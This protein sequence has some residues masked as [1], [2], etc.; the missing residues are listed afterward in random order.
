MNCYKV[1]VQSHIPFYWLILL[2]LQIIVYILDEIFY[3]NIKSNNNP[4]GDMITDEKLQ[5]IINK[6]AAKTSALLAG[7]TDEYLIIDEV[8]PVDQSRL[9][10]QAKFTHSSWRKAFEQQLITIKEHGKQLPY[11]Y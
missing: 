7:K 8:L 6:E 11:S 5:Y 2:S 10:E 4:I 3:K 1:E 9:I